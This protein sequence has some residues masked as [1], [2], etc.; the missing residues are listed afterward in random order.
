M[1]S[2]VKIRNFGNLCT[3]TWDKGC[4]MGK[5]AS[6]YLGSRGGCSE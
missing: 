3:L 6:T 2:D 5:K 1:R 4:E